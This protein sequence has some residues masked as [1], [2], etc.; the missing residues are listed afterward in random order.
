MAL[1][2]ANRVSETGIV[3][4]TG[5]ITLS[6]ASSPLYKPFSQSFDPGDKVPYVLVGD[7]KWEAGYGTYISETSLSRDVA[8][9]TSDSTGV[10]S[11]TT[12]VASKI[13]FNS[14]STVTVFCS[15]LSNLVLGVTETG[16]LLDPS[17]FRKTIVSTNLTALLAEDAM[18]DGEFA[19][20]GKTDS[21][22]QAGLFQWVASEATAPDGVDTF[23]STATG[24]TSLG[25]W[26]RC[27]LNVQGDILGALTVDA[28]TDDGGE[29]K[30]YS[31][32]KGANANS[33]FRVVAERASNALKFKARVNQSAERNFFSLISQ[34]NASDRIE[35]EAP[36]TLQSAAD[37]TGYKAR[38]LLR[39]ASSLALTIADAVSNTAKALT[40]QIPLTYG[41]SYAS[42]VPTLAALKALGSDTSGDTPAFGPAELFSDGEIAL[43]RG[44]TNAGDCKPFTVRWSST[45]TLADNGVSVLRPNYGTAA[46]GAG[47]WLLDVSNVDQ[48]FTSGVATP[49]VKH[50]E[51]FYT[52]GNTPITEL[53]DG[54]EGQTVTIYRGN[55]DIQ[56]Q[57][58]PTKIRLASGLNLTLTATAPTVTLKCIGGVF[59][60]VT[61]AVPAAKTDLSNVT[62]TKTARISIKSGYYDYANLVDFGGKG[63]GTDE[64]AVLA[65]ALATGRPVMIPKYKTDGTGQANWYFPSTY[66]I[67]NGQS[68]IGAE[69]KS[70]IKQGAQPLFNIRG[71]SNFKNLFVDQS[72]QSSSAH[73]TF[74]FD[75]AVTGIQGVR[76][77]G[78]HTGIL[79][80]YAT[81]AGG[82]SSYA[83]TGGENLIV[84][85]RLS[86]S[87]MWGSKASPFKFVKLFASIYL[88]R[89]FVDFTRQ[90][91]LI[92]YAGIDITG[93]AGISMREVCVQGLGTSGTKSSSADG[94]KLIGGAAID[95]FQCR[96]DTV[97][98]IGFNF[99]NL[100]GC[101]FDTLVGS[102]CDQE[103]FWGQ[104]L[105]DCQISNP[106]AGG[107]RYQSGA[108][109]SKVG[110][111]LS[112]S[113]GTIV[114]NLK[115]KSSTGVGMLL[116]NSSSCSINSF[117][118]NDN[119]GYG[120]QETGTSN[121]NIISNGLFNLNGAYNGVTV[122]SGT[123]QS[124]LILAAGTVRNAVGAGSW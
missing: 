111:R 51:F 110:F 91:N 11:T 52:S 49:S 93:G 18:D 114:N 74:L 94:F 81:L 5:S 70:T 67:S 7:G 54:Y 109:A 36:L 122:G 10:N 86:D 121:Y 88:D 69:G 76:I 42:V 44:R 40:K 8:Y 24:F 71:S 89:V 124:N 95:L 14:G 13:S 26:K 12:A 30:L 113:P 60:D 41:G 38:T 9:E 104:N 102:L 80:N 45:S 6:G 37:S 116:E 56:I 117:T 17:P 57:H 97:G 115:I 83:D 99:Q 108:T 39:S 23:R 75:T 112:G 65:A 43:V 107:A 87:V 123:V 120:L 78:V 28:K 79:S 98:G 118:I 33:W 62:D 2:L 20:V 25:L 90:S 72:Q 19:W 77:E 84:D 16:T 3:S 15:L 119:I 66:N 58:D 34:G 35:L 64:S 82:Y 29:V 48:T 100:T 96:A 31:A 101:M 47:R 50:G 21:I 105:S 73:T 53:K 32:K 61:G 46:T 27:S 103:Q 1:K 92:N 22:G 85:V 4:G 68:I 55:Q 63:D 106:Y 59:Y